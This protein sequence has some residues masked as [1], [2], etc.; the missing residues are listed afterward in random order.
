MN[1]RWYITISSG[2]FHRNHTTTSAT[3]EIGKTV[4]LH[5]NWKHKIFISINILPHQHSPS[6]HRSHFLNT[7]PSC[8][9]IHSRPGSCQP[10]PLAIW[11][12]S[13]VTLNMLML[14]NS[15]V[16]FISNYYTLI[17]Q[18]FFLFPPS[19]CCNNMKSLT[20]PCPLKIT[21]TSLSALR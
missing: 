19:S 17:C 20:N 4:K 12:S 21:S 16:I 7:I 6:L 9:H 11:Y 3:V 2:W 5:F 1:W 10:I 18:N 13:T 14:D 15:I 8:I